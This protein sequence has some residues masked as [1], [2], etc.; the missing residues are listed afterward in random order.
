MGLG[1]RLGLCVVG[2]QW[3]H[4]FLQCKFTVS[5]SKVEK[6]DAE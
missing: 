3:W 2:N 5:K 6:D 4:Q 1:Q